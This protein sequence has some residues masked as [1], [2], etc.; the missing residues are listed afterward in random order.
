MQITPMHAQAHTARN[1][2][3]GV[4]ERLKEWKH[5]EEQLNLGS[6]WQRVCEFIAAAVTGINWLAPRQT[7]HLTHCASGKL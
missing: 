7:P 3:I 4:N 5:A 2:L 6:V 1:L